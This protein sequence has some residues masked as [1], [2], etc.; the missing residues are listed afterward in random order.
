M[1]SKKKSYKTRQWLVRGSYK[2]IFQIKRLPKS[3]KK[4]I[5]LYVVIGLAAYGFMAENDP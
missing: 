3:K 1:F 4:H 2:E 5:L